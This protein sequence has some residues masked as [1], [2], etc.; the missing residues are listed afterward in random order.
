M[1]N[2][3]Y[4]PAKQPDY[5]IPGLHGVS[6]GDR[7]IIMHLWDYREKDLKKT[8]WGR[9]HILEHMINYGPGRKKISLSAVK[10][11][12]TNLNLIHSGADSFNF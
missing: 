6:R 8:E 10:K 4:T 1:K 5:S 3:K 12:G 2:K 7:I 11:T 9:L